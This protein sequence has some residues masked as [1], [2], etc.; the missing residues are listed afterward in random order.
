MSVDINSITGFPTLDLTKILSFNPTIIIVL[1]VVILVYFFFFASLGNA[2]TQLGNAEGNNSGLRYLG[3]GSLAIFLVIVLINGMHYLLNIDIITTIKDF[4]SKSPEIDFKINKEIK[5][6]T[7]PE[8]EPEPEPIPEEKFIKQVYHIPENKYTYEDAKAICTAYGS[9]IAN[10]KDIKRAHDEGGEWCSYG[11]SDNQLALFPTQYKKW[12]NL[13]KIKGH[14][15]DC[16]RPG[17]NGGYIGNPN[18]KFGINCF[19]Y[20]P[21]ITPEEAK[22]MSDS[23]PYP[24]TKKEIEFEDRVKYWKNNLKEILVSPF[25]NKRWDVI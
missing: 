24:L 7:L 14:E 18:A 15:N 6:P 17:I 19:G 10:Y 20:K 21:K 22:I 3:L 9:R 13:Q 25:N 16:G 8:P 23:P 5:K 2:N 11:W 4:F 1:V 12:E